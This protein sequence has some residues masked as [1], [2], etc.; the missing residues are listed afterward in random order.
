MHL[1]RYNAEQSVKVNIHSS[2]IK[3]ETI[4]ALLN[5]ER[6]SMCKINV[7][8]LDTRQH[9]TYT[10]SIDI[11]QLDKMKT[12]KRPNHSQTCEIA[13]NGEHNKKKHLSS[14]S[15]KQ[16]RRQKCQRARG[17]KSEGERSEAQKG[18]FVSIGSY[19]MLH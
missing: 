14:K 16:H 6:A 12:K 2:G 8:R 4:K 3:A 15:M 9:H 11:R 18:N 10:A 5:E 17:D 13:M 7:N 1:Y 19:S